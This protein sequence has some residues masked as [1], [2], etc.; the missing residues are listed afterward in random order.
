M[1]VISDFRGSYFF[2]SNFYYSPINFDGKTAPTV[3]HAFQ[4]AKTF[5]QEQRQSILQTP[6]PAQA[7]QLGR[8]VILREDWEKVK[9]DIMLMLLK[10]KFSQADLQQKLLDT[11]KVELIEGNT[12][13]DKIWGC[14]LINGQ[15]IGQN[16]LGKLLMQVRADIQN[17]LTLKE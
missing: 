1:D 17:K 12:W 7:K 2:L 8:S 16:H 3:E 15:W 5:N 6:S 11:G 4:A 14:V 10:Q 13:N 9:F